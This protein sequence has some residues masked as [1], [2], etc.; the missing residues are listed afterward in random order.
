MS[1]MDTPDVALAPVNDDVETMTLT[2]K[3][4]SFVIDVLGLAAMECG[5]IE[6][7][8]MAVSDTPLSSQTT[9]A[10]WAVLAQRVHSL[11]VQEYFDSLSVEVFWMESYNL[12]HKFRPGSRIDQATESSWSDLLT[13]LLEFFEKCDGMT[14]IKL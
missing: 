11:L 13:S 12:M 4:F 9:S 3:E 8:D 5:E 6:P 10:L 14:F 7:Y 2:V 1:I